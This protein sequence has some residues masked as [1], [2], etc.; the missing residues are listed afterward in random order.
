MTLAASL[1][2]LSLAGTSG[3]QLIDGRASGSASMTVVGSAGN[4]SAALDGLT[5]LPPPQYTG[6]ATIRF[7][8]SYAPQSRDTASPSADSVEIPGNGDPAGPHASHTM[9]IAIAPAN[10]SPSLSAVREVS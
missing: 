3:L 5:F 2:T 6:D 9:R 4:I 1:G 8:I 10:D 7:E